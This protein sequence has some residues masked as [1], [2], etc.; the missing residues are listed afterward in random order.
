MSNIG[1]CAPMPLWHNPLVPNQTTSEQLRREAEKLRETAVD[2]M[3][4]AALLITQS[5]ELEKRILAR[6]KAKPGK[7][8]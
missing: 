6:D 8:P 3:D 4:H 5:V 1:H 2:L 7:K